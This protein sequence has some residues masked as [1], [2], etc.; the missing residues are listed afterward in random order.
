M[1]CKRA[2]CIANQTVDTG[3]KSKRHQWD[4]GLIDCDLS[5]TWLQERDRDFAG[6]PVA[7]S[8]LPKQVAQVQS[9]VRELDPT[10]CS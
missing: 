4:T 8:P 7:D 10:R 9:P 3:N 6:G 5:D 2:S 1:K